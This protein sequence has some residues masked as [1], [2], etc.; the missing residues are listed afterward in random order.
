MRSRQIIGED[1]VLRLGAGIV[2][3]LLLLAAYLAAG[4]ARAHMQGLGEI[5]GAMPHPHCGWC[6]GA[7]SL[8]L[9][10]LAAFSL[11]L[12]PQRRPVRA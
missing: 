2:G 4:L 6:Y 9:V 3:G 11:A 10:G 12:R 1:A 7:A 8:L 5:C